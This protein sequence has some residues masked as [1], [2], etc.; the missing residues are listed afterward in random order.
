M[1]VK[2][3]LACL[4]IMCWSLNLHRWE[5]AQLTKTGLL[6]RDTYVNKAEVAGFDKDLFERMKIEREKG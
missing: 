2:L 3:I 6:S 1:I 4:L 5:Q